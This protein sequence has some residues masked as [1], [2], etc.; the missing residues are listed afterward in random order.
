MKT[1]E[2]LAQIMSPKQRTSGNDINAAYG[3]LVILLLLT[4]EQYPKS[5][6][7]VMFVLLHFP[8]MYI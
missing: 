1:V 7:I 8:I 4:K 2:P 5:V 3:D 6:F